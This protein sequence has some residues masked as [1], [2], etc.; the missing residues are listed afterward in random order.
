MKYV[1]DLAMHNI[2]RQVVSKIFKAMQIFQPRYFQSR[3]DQ[4]SL[5]LCQFENEIHAKFFI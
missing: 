4:S 3:M 5:P 2:T 1:F